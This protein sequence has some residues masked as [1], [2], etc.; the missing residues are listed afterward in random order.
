MGEEPVQDWQQGVASALEWWRDAGVDTLVEDDPRDWLA[1]AAPAAAAPEA[2]TIAAAP[3]SEILPATLDDFIAWRMS[4]A[5]PEAAWM[6]RMIAPSGPAGAELAVMLDMPEAE[7]GETLLGGA[8]GRLFDRMLAAIGLARESIHLCS[9]AVARP[10]TGMIPADQ[11]ARLAHLARHYLTLLRPKRLLLLGKAA[12][13]V[14]G[15]TGSARA[16]GLGDVNLS[17][18]NIRVV[19]SHPPRFLLT[20]PAAKSEAWKHLLLLSRGGE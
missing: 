18:G 14:L 3:Q 20:H 16:A 15:D 6:S 13:G 2:Q 11:E 1:R 12:E 7:D 9:F 17:G 4:A 10:I 19:A 8:A 5:A